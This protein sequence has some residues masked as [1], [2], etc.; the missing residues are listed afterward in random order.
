MEMSSGT[1]L[2]ELGLKLQELTGVKADTM[3]LIVPRS[4]EKTSK[5]LS[6]FSDEQAFL[7]LEETSITKV[8]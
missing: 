4:S 8:P 6:P 2:K 3:R 5:L 7:S 1:T